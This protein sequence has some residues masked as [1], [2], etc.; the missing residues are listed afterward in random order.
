MVDLKIVP[1][2][3]ATLLAFLYACDLRVKPGQGFVVVVP[4]RGECEVD[5][6]RKLKESVKRAHDRR[7]TFD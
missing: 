2:K 1:I 4:I 5:E 6:G 7:S 3:D